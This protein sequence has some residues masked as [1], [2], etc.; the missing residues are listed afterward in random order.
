MKFYLRN[1]V[2]GDFD[3]FVGKGYKNLFYDYD[4]ANN[5]C[6]TW[7]SIFD[8]EIEYFTH[9][10]NALEYCNDINKRYSNS[11]KVIS[12][13]SKEY[14]HILKNILIRNIIE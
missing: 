6:K 9:K 11:I 1:I 3:S 8:P 10:A 14:D 2:A 13:N 7:C 4:Y 5:N 12:N